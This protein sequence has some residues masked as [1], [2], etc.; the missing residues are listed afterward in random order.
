MLAALAGAPLIAFFAACA[1]S[2]PR[3]PTTDVVALLPWGQTDDLTYTLRDLGGRETATGRLSVRVVG[4]QT[5]LVQ[6]YRSGANSDEITVVVDS[7]TLKP[8]SSKRVIQGSDGDET[9]EVTYTE[10]GAVIKQGD[11]QSGLSVP[12]HSYDNDSSLFL[13]RT[14]D[15]REG[16]VG[17]Y[18]AIITNR[19]TRQT[20]ELRVTGKEQVTVPAGTFT[21]WRL[22]VTSAN[23]EQVAWYADTPARTLV[24]Y[25]NDRGTVFELQSQP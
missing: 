25:D 15:F 5:T 1:V 13:W 22:E 23:A 8:Q 6:Q 24:K 19:R 3:G 16:Y 17:R 10:Q 7:A 12:E 20:V 11:K 21:A 4:S 9:V 2:G 18:T 14:I